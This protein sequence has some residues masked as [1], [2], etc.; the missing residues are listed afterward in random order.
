MKDIARQMDELRRRNFITRVAKSALGV[1]LLPASS[2]IAASG[3]KGPLNVV[4][5]NAPCKNLIFLYMQGGM[6]HV[7]TFDPKTESSVKGN[8][9]P[10]K[11]NADGVQLSN[12]LPGLGKVADKLAVI[13]SMSTKTGDHAGANYLMHTAFRVQP[14]TSHPQIGSWA[15]NFLGRRN[16]SLPDSVVIGG[17]NPGPGFFAPDHSPFPI[18]DAQKGISDMLPKLGKERFNHRVDLARRFSKVFEERFPHDDVKSYSKFYDETIKFFDSVS[19]DAFNIGKE[20]AATQAKYGNNRFA[21]GCL[22]ARRLIENNVRYV[23][24]RYDR[25]WDVMHG[26]INP[27]ED[28]AEGLDRPMAALITDLESRG[29]LKD[30][31][32]VLATEFGRTPKINERGGRDHHPRAFSSVIAGGGIS[33]GQ[34]IGATD[35][36]GFAVKDTPVSPEDLHT[37]IGYA[38]GLPVDKRIHGSGGRPFFLGNKGRVIKELFA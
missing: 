3:D 18:G 38:M 30:T 10:S 17:G 7:D 13:R 33:G 31:M 34:I 36:K 4:N 21:K 19:V 11:S 16:Q 12:F 8:A 29:L 32:V 26:G 37:S 15:Q 6:S 1:S 22:L 27:V 25:N 28:L 9:S 2:A 14:G 24:V 20:D 23:E 35:E 5:P